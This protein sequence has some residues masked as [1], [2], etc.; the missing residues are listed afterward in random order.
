M[1]NQAMNELGGR[2]AALRRDRGLTQDELALRLCI[3]PQAVS[4]WERGAG[5]PDV[6]VFPA[7]AEALGVSVGELFGEGGGAPEND[8][9]ERFDELPLVARHEALGCYSDKKVKSCDALGVDFEDGSRADY[10]TRTVTN[11]GKGEIRLVENE[12]AARPRYDDKRTEYS[13]TLTPFR[14]IEIINNFPCDMKIIP[15]TDDAWRMHA[16]GSARFLSLIEV[17][18]TGETLRLHVK[19]DEGPGGRGGDNMLTLEVGFACGGNIKATVNGCGGLETGFPFD[20]GELTVNG[21]GDIVMG[22]FGSLGVTVNGSGDIRF[23]NVAGET[24][25]NVNGSGD[26]AGGEL[27]RPLRV[28]ISGSGDIKG[29]HACDVTL[30]IAGAGDIV[31]DRIDEKLDANV[32]GSGDIRCGGELAS[33][34]LSITGS[35]ELQG[36]GLTT[37]EATIRLAGSSSAHVGHIVGRSTETV[38]KTANLRVDRRG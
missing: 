14:H 24:R 36:K 31:I 5:L 17:S 32:T 38:A 22:D 15:T 9:P 20:E 29:K 3:T 10:A 12:H 1:S 7:L 11:C 27:G 2:I 26:I 8:L 18:V 37:K 13:E 25:L 21:S 34:L 4:K 35:G 19:S 23:G 33:L 6:T 30:R 16:K 28:G